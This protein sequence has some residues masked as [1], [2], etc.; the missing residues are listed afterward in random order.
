M[1]VKISEVPKPLLDKLVTK[2]PQE[3]RDEYYQQYENMYN[4]R[5]QALQNLKNQ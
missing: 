5:V 1:K 3:Y 4:L 2:F